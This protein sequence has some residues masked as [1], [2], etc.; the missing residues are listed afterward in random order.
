MKKFA[1]AVAATM[2]ALFMAEGVLRLTGLG[3]IQ[4]EIQFGKITGAPS[5]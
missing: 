4:P 3:T 2:I 5:G 1:L